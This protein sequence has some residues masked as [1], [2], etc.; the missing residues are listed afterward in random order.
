MRNWLQWTG[1]ESNTIF[2]LIGTHGGRVYLSARQIEL[3]G[4]R[5]ADRDPRM[6]A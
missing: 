4:A 6:S 1:A 3:S 2:E 5:A